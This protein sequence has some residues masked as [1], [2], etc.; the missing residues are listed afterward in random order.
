MIRARGLCFSYT[1]NAPFVLDGVDFD[2]RA[3]DYISIVGDNGCGKS[4]LIRIILRAIKPIRGSIEC[5]AARIGYVPQRN[6]FSN[7]QFPITVFE[8][9]NS[10]RNLLKEPHR[11]E[12]FRMLDWVGMADFAN[13]LVGTLSGGQ[14]QKTMIARAMLGKPD[15]LILDEP[16]TGVDRSSQREIYG[17]LKEWNVHNG[18]TILSVEHNLDAAVANSTLIYH[19]SG[20]SGHMCVPERYM[21]EY[22][23]PDEPSDRPY[24][25]NDEVC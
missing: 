24:E 4:T 19:M 20:G 2:V 8:A 9:M 18:L 15:L 7:L 6:D 1:G 5:T 25:R 3:G 12:I 22:V 23:Q 17:L 14:L 11:S 13:R 16:S 21:R 10:Y